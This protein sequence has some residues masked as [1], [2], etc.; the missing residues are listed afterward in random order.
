MSVQGTLLF[1]WNAK[2]DVLGLRMSEN[3]NPHQTPRSQEAQSSR[4]R[5]SAPPLPGLWHSFG[6]ES[7]E[8]ASSRDPKE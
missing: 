4:H 5:L 7:R 1:S 8:L 3:V 2:N 6:T